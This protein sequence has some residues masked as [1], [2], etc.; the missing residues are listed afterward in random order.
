MPGPIDTRNSGVNGLEARGEGFEGVSDSGSRVESPKPQARA[1]TVPMAGGNVY[2]IA[3]RR[4]PFVDTGAQS[5]SVSRLF[6][7][8]TVTQRD[9]VI[10][11]RMRTAAQ[12]ALMWA[13][14]AGIGGSEPQVRETV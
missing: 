5:P 10:A 2:S 1:A 4:A 12:E 11:A 13:V 7:P 8:A 9:E 14:I 6:A 3:G